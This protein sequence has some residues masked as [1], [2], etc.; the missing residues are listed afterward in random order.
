MALNLEQF[1]V[2][3]DEMRSLGTKGLIMKHSDFVSHWTMLFLLL[4]GFAAPLSASHANSQIVVF[5]TTTSSSNSSGLTET[6]A[7]AFQ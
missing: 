1:S 2:L 5:D 6:A 3:S 7:D 4:I